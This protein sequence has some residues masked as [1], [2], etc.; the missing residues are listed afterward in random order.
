MFLAGPKSTVICSEGETSRRTN[1]TPIVGDRNGVRRPGGAPPPHPPA[2]SAAARSRILDG[3]A[4]HRCA[5]AVWLEGVAGT[6][7]GTSLSPAAAGLQDR[8]GRR[9]PLL[10]GSHPHCTDPRS[11]VMVG[12][13]IPLGMDPAGAIGIVSRVGLERASARDRWSSGLG[14]GG[15]LGSRR[16]RQRC[17]SGV[18]QILRQGLTRQGVVEVEVDN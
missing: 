9:L 3:P 1:P 18:R 8:E 17:S 15:W 13:A 4:G 16:C 11:V 12:E 7:R 6:K 10:V 14:S 5:Q 2:R